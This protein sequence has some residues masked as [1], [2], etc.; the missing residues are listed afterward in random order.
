MSYKSIYADRRT[1]RFLA[2]GLRVLRK[3]L[4]QLSQEGHPELIPKAVVRDMVRFLAIE[5]GKREG[6]IPEHWKRD[7]LSGQRWYWK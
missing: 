4:R 1:D 2:N 6:L 5:I 3:E 7:Y